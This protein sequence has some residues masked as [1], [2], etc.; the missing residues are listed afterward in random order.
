L[1]IGIA[2]AC[3]DDQP[4]PSADASAATEVPRAEPPPERDPIEAVPDCAT[5]EAR[6]ARV[7]ED[8]VLL[9]ILCPGLAL[10]HSQTRTIVLALASAS[11]AARAIPALAG[12]PELQGIV[13][14]AGP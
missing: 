11:A 8:L 3:G 6:A 12:E 2:S 4:Q 14:L 10:D 1:V 7:T 13:R 5:L 9:P